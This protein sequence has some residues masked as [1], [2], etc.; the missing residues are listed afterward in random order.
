VTTRAPAA[1]PLVTTAWLAERLGRPNIRVVDGS[2]HMPALRRDAR[3]E[4]AE[5]HIPGAVFFDIDAIADPRTPL[6]HMLP[7]AA[8]FAR[9]VGSLGIGSRDR[10]VVYDSRGVTSAARVWWTFRAFGHDAVAVLDGGLPRWRAEGRPVESGQPVPRPRRFTARLRRRLVRDLADVRAN[11]TRRREQV[12]DAR[13]RGRFDGTEPEPRAGLRAGHIPG[14][15]NLP[16]DQLYQADGTFL[17]SD[18]LRRRFEAAGLDL[19]KPVVTSCG[20]GITA[21]V[22]ALG[23]YVLGRDAA[24]YDGSWTEWGGRADTPV[25]P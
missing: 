19:D 17:P 4:F 5:S 15:L 7:S 25:E 3:A 20:S 22:L 14:S 16:Y 24:V 6:P 13:S 2:W 9:S 12:L 1:S 18:E 21:S 10:V 11:L 23:L 8:A